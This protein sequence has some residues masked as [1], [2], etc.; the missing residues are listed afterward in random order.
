[1]ANKI[2]LRVVPCNCKYLCASHHL[3][4]DSYMIFIRYMPEVSF[5]VLYVSGLSLM[6]IRPRSS[7][8]LITL[9]KVIRLSTIAKRSRLT[10]C[11]ITHL[12]L[13]SSSFMRC[14]PGRTIRL[15][16]LLNTRIR[17]PG[18]IGSRRGVY[19]D[20]ILRAIISTASPH[21]H[22]HLLHH[23]LGTHKDCSS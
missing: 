13:S 18:R 20:L 16:I 21:S 2:G 10:S 23:P 12:S 15:I 5:L 19:I 8:Y 14:A 6:S 17:F 11:T 22:P 4:F 9:E 7:Y 1:M 3:L